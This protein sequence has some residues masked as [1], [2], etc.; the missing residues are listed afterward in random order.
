MPA[1]NGPGP[2]VV[3]TLSAVQVR[4]VRSRSPYAPVVGFSAAVRA[5]DFVFV[6]GMT[7][8]DENGEVLGGDDPYAQARA[9]LHKVG[10]ILADAGASL[11]YVVQT[12]VYIAAAEHWEAAGRAHGEV[13]GTTLPATAMLVTQLVDPRMLVEIEAV[14][15]VGSAR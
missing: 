12:R 9:A 15:Y 14:A 5:G 1:A 11:A 8:V 4:R 6:A 3:G 10:E 2:P 7:S 13:F